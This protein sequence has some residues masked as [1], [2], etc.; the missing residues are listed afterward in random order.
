M[1]RHTLP[2]L[3]GV[4]HLPA[5][6][7]DA[8]APRGGDFKPALE[9]AR[10]DGLRLAAGGVDGI[11]VE[12][13]GS[14]PF[15]KGSAADPLPPH[16]LA[17]LTLV[18]AQ[19]RDETQLPIGVNC[20]RNDAYSAL[21]IAAAADLDFIRVNIH[22]GAYL[23][24]QGVIE[25]EAPRTLAY[26]RLLESDVAIMA[27][28]MVKHASPLAPLDLLQCARDT[29]ERG[30]ADALIVTG[31]GTGRPTEVADLERLQPLRDRAPLYLGSGLTLEQL[32]RLAPLIDGAI[33]GTALKVEGVL[34]APID[35][36]RVRSFAAQKSSLGL[37]EEN[38]AC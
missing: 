5:L 17:A 21:G 14:A 2:R 3:I 8:A 6:P 30:G 7:G 33:V 22:S 26:R 36:L 1:S 25:G 34:S 18:A 32:P 27:D 9:F 10:A 38:N 23:T 11:I 35:E 31:S 16:Q 15:V 29:V 13:F 24:D 37:Q 28:V 19:L 12:N 20:L 4:V